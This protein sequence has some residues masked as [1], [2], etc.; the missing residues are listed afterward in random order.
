MKSKYLRLSIVVS[1]LL[2]SL[3][4]SAVTEEIPDMEL[5]NLENEAKTYELENHLKDLYR[6]FLDAEFKGKW[7]DDSSVES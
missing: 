5:Q 2:V 7:D 1:H 6:E 4:V 3:S